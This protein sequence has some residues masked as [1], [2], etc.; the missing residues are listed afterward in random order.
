MLESADAGHFQHNGIR[1]D[2][3]AG[4]LAK[5]FRGSLPDQFGHPDTNR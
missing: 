4:S 1:E 2:E 5:F 3:R